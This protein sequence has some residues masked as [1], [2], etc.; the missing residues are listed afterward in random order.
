MLQDSPI[1]TIF[2]C[3]N[4]DLHFFYMGVDIMGERVKKLGSEG[5][6]E[7]AWKYLL[8]LLLGTL[9]LPYH[10]FDQ[11]VLPWN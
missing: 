8:G 6:E 1:W 4:I 5:E 7:T 3:L 2:I 11:A 9:M 10:S